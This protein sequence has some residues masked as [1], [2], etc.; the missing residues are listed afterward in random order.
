MFL[1]IL[2][3]SRLCHRLRFA[4]RTNIHAADEYWL[5]I[6]RTVIEILNRT[7]A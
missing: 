4:H 6:D 3:I 5:A 2:E 7:K 1:P